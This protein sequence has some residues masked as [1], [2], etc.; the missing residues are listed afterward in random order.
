MRQPLA[1]RVDG[2]AGPLALDSLVKG[3]LEQALWSKKLSASEHSGMKALPACLLFQLFF[4]G[5][6]HVLH[7]VLGNCMPFP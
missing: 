5:A 2:H 4:R 1:N 3:G 6:E 7:L